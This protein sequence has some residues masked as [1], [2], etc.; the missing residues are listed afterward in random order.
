VINPLKVI[1][2]L[3]K[4]KS[5]VEKIVQEAKNMDGAKPGWKTSTFWIKL[6]TVDAPVLYMAIKGFLPPKVAMI[7]EVIALGLYAIYRTVIDVM[8]QL[9]AVKASDGSITSVNDAQTVVVN[10]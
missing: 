4:E 3:F 6:F 7:I 10:K 9:Q 8:K 5:E 1:A 2:A